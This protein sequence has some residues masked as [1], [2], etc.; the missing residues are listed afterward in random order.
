MGALAYLLIKNVVTIDVAVRNQL[1]KRVSRFIHP[2][3]FEH[4]SPFIQPKKN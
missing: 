2:F 1:W 3:E 4:I